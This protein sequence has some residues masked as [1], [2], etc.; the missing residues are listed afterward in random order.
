MELNTIKNNQT[1]GQAAASLNE[2]F[3]KVR[4][5]MEKVKN[6]TTR[7]KGYFKTVEALESAFPTASE[8]DKAYVGAT[9]PYTV[10]NY[11]GGVWTTDGATG[12]DESVNLGDYYTKED[13]DALIKESEEALKED[14]E[15]LTAGGVSFATSDTLGGVKANP[16]TEKDT[17]EIHITKDGFLVTEPTTSGEGEGDVTGVKGNAETTYRKGNVNIT[18]ANIG[19][20]NVDNTADADKSVKYAVSSTKASQDGNGNV[21]AETYAT[22]TEV[23][24]VESIAN[25]AKTVANTAKNAVKT[26]EG[27]S[28]TTTAQETLAAQVVTIEENKANIFNLEKKV[29][30]IESSVNDVISYGFDAMT[31]ITTFTSKK[32]SDDGSLADYNFD[33]VRLYPIEGGQVYKIRGQHIGS[34]INLFAFY[35]SKEIASDSLVLMG[36]KSGATAAVTD[37]DITVVAPL[38]ATHLAVTRYKSAYEGIETHLQ[39]QKRVITGGIIEE[40][41]NKIDGFYTKSYTSIGYSRIIDGVYLNSDGSMPALSVA[42]VKVYPVSGGDEIKIKATYNTGVSRK[43][44]VYSSDETLDATTKMVVGPYVTE[45]YEDIVKI[46]DGAA[47][48]AVEEY[49][50]Y[51]VETSKATYRLGVSNSEVAKDLYVTYSTDDEITVTRK[52]S[53]NK[54]L[55]IKLKKFGAN[56]LM[57][58]HS[59]GF[60]NNEEEFV[61]QNLPTS[62]VSSG[63]DWVGPYIMKA[64]TREG[65]YNGFTGGCHGFNGDATGASTAE[66]TSISVIADTRLV[67]L[68][69]YRADNLRVVVVNE[70]QGGNTKNSS[71]TGDPILRETVT[72]EFK[73]KKLHVGVLMEALE[74]LTIQTYYGMQV[75]SFNSSIRF[76]S[77]KITGGEFSSSPSTSNKNLKWIIC[78]RADG[79]KLKAQMDIQGLGLKGYSNQYAYAFTSG[80]KAY[81]SLVCP[82]KP[83]TLYT[84]EQAYWTGFYQ[85]TS[86]EDL[87]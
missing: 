58:I 37:Y 81:Y 57:Q 74:D 22:K 49:K 7:N 25:E 1:W 67:G 10:Y 43:Y 65:T 44:A 50:G 80:S 33:N 6:A 62:F 12:G 63:S 15:N 73:G 34:L 84:G 18:P 13:T 35:N 23:S 2:N 52:Y 11:I 32:I 82:D 46:P 55:S 76:Y 45:S 83:L 31:A 41:Q 38:G 56:N 47:A 21:I 4:T 77:D 48:I 53:E 30:I 20:G 75:N 3:S 66:T 36:K 17:Q 27:L 64:D 42:Q 16:A 71:G 59:Y 39:G 78:E 28:N 24:N 72:Y 70:I 5:D 68:G 87:L 61:S 8:G 14:I 69:S 60:V 9:Y 51:P 79:N 40:V 54:D 86:M 29:E 19:L 26:L 85:I